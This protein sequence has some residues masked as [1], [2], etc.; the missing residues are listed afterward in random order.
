MFRAKEGE[1]QMHASILVIQTLLTKPDNQLIRFHP[2]A[3]EAL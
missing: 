1:T 3:P 2:D